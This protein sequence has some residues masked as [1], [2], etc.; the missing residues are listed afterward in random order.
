MA[1]PALMPRRR[2]KVKMTAEILDYVTDRTR[3]KMW[4]HLSLNERVVKIYERFEVHG[5]EETKFGGENPNT[6]CLVP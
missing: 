6:K 3:L 1:N 2:N 5:T 4:A